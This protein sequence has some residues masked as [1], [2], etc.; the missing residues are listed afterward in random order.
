[1]PHRRARY[2][3]VEGARMKQSAQ[4]GRF[5]S[6]QA[7]RRVEDESLLTG[8]G[9]SSTIVNAPGQAHVLFLRSTYPHARIV[10]IDTSAAARMPGVV[11]VVTGAR[12]REGRRQAA[13][14]VRR[15]SGAPTA[16]RRRRRRD[17]R[18]PSTPFASS[19]K[20]WPPSSPR[21][22]TQARDALEAIDVRYEAL[23]CRRRSG[24][25]R[26]AGLTA[27]LAGGDGQH[28]RGDSPRRCR[29]GDEGVRERR[30]RRRARPRQPEARAVPDRAA[31]GARELRREGRSHHAARQQPDADRVCATRCA[32]RCSASRHDKVRV[33]V[34]D[35]GGGF[36]M[37]TGLYPEDVVLAYCARKLEA[38]AQMVRRAHRRV[39][40]GLAWPRRHEQGG[41]GARRVRPRARA[42]RVVAREPRR[43]CD[44]RRRRDPAADRA[45]GV[46]QHLRH[47]DHRH[48][49][50]RRAH[51]HESDG[52]LPRRRPARGDL[53]HRAADGRGGAEARRSIPRSSGGGT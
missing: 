38:S 5:G 41:A 40:R 44:A 45:V 15:I 50:P 1:M 47:S 7:V 20:P 49:H 53:P 12:A 18:S 25:G 48:S 28:R 10:G 39:P 19:A 34:G 2:G 16:R 23:P 4:Y 3:S 26:R 51:A 43:V 21:R 37:K 30:A 11:A 6:G 42:A 36:G 8:R 27:G 22:A 17:M 9:S 32:T 14:D 24:R 52:C 13:S 35:V 31:R 29:G 33:L 46:D